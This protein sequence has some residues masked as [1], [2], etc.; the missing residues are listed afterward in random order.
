MQPGES[1]RTIWLRVVNNCRMSI[2][3]PT[4]GRLNGDEG[5][6]VPDRVIAEEPM[7]EITAS[8][9]GPGT[10]SAPY[11]NPTI[12]KEGV[13]TREEQAPQ[14]HARKPDQSAKEPDSIPAG[15]AYVFLGE[16][17]RHILSGQ[18]LLVGIPIEHV[19]KNWFVRLQFALDLGNYWN[20]PRTNLDLKWYELPE[21]ARSELSVAKEPTQTKLG[22]Q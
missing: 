4:F 2:L 5:D 18:S 15:Y 14:E 11:L 7:F 19:G 12:D 1:G 22:K 16:T 8:S 21:S 9:G 6:T 17:P 13:H 10:T 20:E 3:F